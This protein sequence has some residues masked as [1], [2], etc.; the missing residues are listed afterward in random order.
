MSIRPSDPTQIG[1]HSI[2][3]VIKQWGGAPVL[4]WEEKGDTTIWAVRRL[5]AIGVP[6]AIIGKIVTTPP[7]QMTY[8]SIE[9]LKLMEVEVAGQPS[10][11]HLQFPAS[12]TVF[13]APAMARAEIRMDNG[14]ILPPGTVVVTMSDLRRPNAPPT[15]FSHVCFLKPEQ[16]SEDVNRL[17][18]ISYHLPGEATISTARV[19]EGFLMLIKQGWNPAP[20]PAIDQ[21]ETAPIDATKE[22]VT[23]LTDNL[24][25]Q[26]LHLRKSADPRAPDVLSAPNN[27]IPGGSLVKRDPAQQCEVW[28]GSGRG[29][30]DAD[31]IWCPIQY[32]NAR[33]WVNGYFLALTDGRRVACAMY[34]DAKGCPPAPPN[35]PAQSMVLKSTTAANAEPI[36][37]ECDVRGRVVWPSWHDVI[38]IDQTWAINDYTFEKVQGTVRTVISR[39]SGVI[40]ETY[41]KNGYTLSGMYRIGHCK[42]VLPGEQKF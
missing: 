1:V 26:D 37:L 4:F 29:A 16:P 15:S 3:A 34:P 28:M 14:T 27:T 24:V 17:C 40:T 5:K 18:N 23:D 41:T 42:K 32:G 21:P 9:D 8:L 30:Q 11:F 25:T 6:D 39:S 13:L 7:D 38:Q 12:D 10:P 22:Q 19:R 20:S 35:P 36:M 33:G 2:Y 31:N